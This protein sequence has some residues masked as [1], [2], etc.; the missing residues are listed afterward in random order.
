MRAAGCPL[1]EATGGHLVSE[2]GKFRLVRADEDG[3][4][5][6]YRLVWGEHVREFSDLDDADRAVFLEAMVTVERL[7]RHHVQ[8]AKVNLASLGNI[9]P[10]LH[11]H[12]IARFE[13]DPAWPAAAW[14]TPQRSADAAAVAAIEARRPVLEAALAQALAPR[15]ANR[16][17][18]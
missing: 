1:C 14:A 5:A 4:P 2:T 16:A 11:W 9:V 18:S 12:V 15:P 7:L 13:W 3:Y 8:P 17:G 10:H 6:F